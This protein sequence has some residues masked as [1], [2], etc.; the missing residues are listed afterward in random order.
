M[1]AV[2][3]ARLL[4]PDP[5]EQY[6]RDIHAEWHPM[7]RSNRFPSVEER[8]KL[9]MSNWY[10]PPCQEASIGRFAGKYQKSTMRPN[11][12]NES[13]PVLTISDVWDSTSSK[14]VTI[15][16][17]VQPDRNILLHRATVEDCARSNEEYNQQGA[18][19]TESRVQRR[20]NMNSYCSEVVELINI[21][22]RL[23]G[24][25]S[26]TPIL[27]Y[28]G[29]GTALCGRDSFEVPV[30]AKYRAG[31]TKDYI[32][33]VTGGKRTE[34]CLEGARPP[35]ETAY[36]Q[37]QY[38]NKLSP[39]L[40][41]LNFNRHWNTLPR[42]LRKD[43]PWEQ[44]TSRAFWRGD[45]TGTYKGA[46][47]LER[48]LSNQRCRFVLNHAGSK[49]IDAGIVNP[50]RVLKNST[51]NGIEVTKAGVGF[52]IIQ[53]YKVV[54]CL[55]GNDL[56][57]GLKWMLQSKSVVLMP[58][59]TRTSWAMEE[60]LEPWVHYVPMFSNGSNAEEMVRWVLD[61]EQGARRIA[62]RATLFMYDLV[63]HPD[64][65]SD[66]DKIKEE[67]ARRYRDLWL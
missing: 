49:L 7:N 10:L 34:L 22:Q 64:A 52:D 40:W 54:I 56:S 21:M 38:R 11:G 33:H 67:M 23:D 3:K 61:N 20:W 18:L 53:Q 28:F 44:K 6:F 8:V 46:T 48:C 29:D 37:G 5:V 26:D 9:Y 45:A 30:I 14:T 2:G 36:H 63:Y 15:D 47:D 12:T 60:L 50:L 27:A 32:A 39:I 66:N 16:S 25:D 19:F 59:P 57:S 62:E 42:A 41:R 4:D 35:L 58:P 51:I 43:I 55:E 17:L 65:A 31:T 24:E 1:N 13:W